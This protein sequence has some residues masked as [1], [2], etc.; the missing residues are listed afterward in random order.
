MLPPDYDGVVVIGKR[1]KGK[2]TLVR[3]LLEGEPRVMLYDAKGELEEPQ[4]IARGELPSMPKTGVFRGYVPTAGQPFDECEWSAYLAI[5]LGRCVYVVDELPDALE[6]RDPDTS[7]A[8]VT[9]MGRKRAIR[10]IYSFQRAGEVPRMVTAQAC[11]W[12]LF[13]TNEPTDLLYIKQSVSAEAANLVRTMPRGC[14][15]HVKDG[16]VVGV[17]ETRHP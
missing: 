17:M 3:Q 5:Q 2:S 12:F 10:F 16:N 13:Q 14:A 4:A 6:G 7:F 9:R 8:W 11:D 15:V 1:K